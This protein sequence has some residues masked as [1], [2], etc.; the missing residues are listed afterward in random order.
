MSG[1]WIDL[2][3]VPDIPDM[4]ISA[5]GQ[6]D[7]WTRIDLSDPAYAIPPDPPA[8]LDLIYH[9]RRHVLSG[10]PESAKTLVSYILILTALRHQHPV[11]I[12]DF[13]MGP[14]AARRL[15]HELGAT[16][17][18][19]ASIYYVAPEHPPK[20][21]LQDVIDHGTRLAL[22]DAAI[23]AY[24]TQ[25]LDDNKR[26]D[27][28]KFAR[29]WITP[30][31]KAEI[32]TLLVDHVTKNVDTRGKFTIGS[33]RKL[34]A[35]DVHLGLEA[36]ETISRGGAGLIKIHVHKD[37]PGFLQRP[38]A[39]LVGLQSDPETHQIRWQIKNAD[40]AHGG[41]RPTR[42]MEK[43]SKLI[44]QT[45]LTRADIH[46]HKLGKKIGVVA[47][48]DRLLEENYATEIVPGKKGTK[49]S[50]NRPYREENE[51]SF[52]S[53]PSFPESSPERSG[54]VPPLQ[55][56]TGTGT[57]P[58]TP[59]LDVFDPSVQELLDNPEQADNDIPF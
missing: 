55:G 6:P 4:S 18:E 48:I 9:A 27:A 59:Q 40:S 41:F 3:D 26:Q 35:A 52:P 49:I 57:I 58:G 39:C 19:L 11:A 54:N 32:A 7:S 8:I 12:I 2:S 34:G 28:E 25:G 24:D 45:A 1:Q 17:D 15:L 14:T 22:I 46:D 20:D 36:I 10:A 31:W 53:F 43:V 38:H 42:L 56:G 50:S 51:E 47:A 23:G 29:T 21:N 37:R 16:Q 13:E 44:E 33:E 30:L 5:N